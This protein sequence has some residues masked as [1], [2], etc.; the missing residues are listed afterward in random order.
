M[1]ASQFASPGQAR[2]GEF[3]GMPI[4][5]LDK[6]IRATQLCGDAMVHKVMLKLKG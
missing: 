2:V 1:T 4:G 6:L 3:D 5:Q